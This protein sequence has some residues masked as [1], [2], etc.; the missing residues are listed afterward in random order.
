MLLAVDTGNIDVQ[1]F[2]RSCQGGQVAP[3]QAS[4]PARPQ[5]FSASRR[6]ACEAGFFIFHP[7]A[8]ALAI[9]MDEHLARPAIVARAIRVIETLANCPHPRDARR[10]ERVREIGVAD[11]LEGSRADGGLLCAPAADLLCR[12]PFR[13]S[14]AAFHGFASASTCRP[15]SVIRST[16]T[17]STSRPARVR[18][19]VAVASPSTMIST[20]VS[21]SPRWRA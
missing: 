13:E 6:T 20:M 4:W 1:S 10:M 15:L 5:S 14:L 8:A 3:P 19:G 9:W 16:A 21:T 18:C 11:F 17:S 2:P 12:S 7:M